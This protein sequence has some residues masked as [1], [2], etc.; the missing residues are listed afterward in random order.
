MRRKI[1][2]TLSPEEVKKIIAQP[3][4]RVPTGLRNKAI[5]SFIWDSGAR[6]SDV[7]NLK[8][9][10][11]SIGKREAVILNGK[12]GIDRKLSFSDY[13]ADLLSLLH[14][15]SSTSIM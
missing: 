14:N 8:P 15:Y 12:G 11:L 7:I 10:N 1:P 3:N 5:L 2:V 4:K 13:T 9:G 6:V